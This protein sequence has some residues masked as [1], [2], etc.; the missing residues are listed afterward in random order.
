MHETDE[1]CIQYVFRFWNLKGRDHEGGWNGNVG[2]C[3][4]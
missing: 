2:V 4:K 3:H 1:K